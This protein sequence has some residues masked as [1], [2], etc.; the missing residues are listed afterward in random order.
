MAGLLRR[1][2][3]PLLGNYRKYLLVYGIAT[4]FVLF[5]GMAI[6]WMVDLP[7]AAPETY[8][9]EILLCVCIFGAS[10]LYRERQT[11]GK[12]YLKELLVL[13]MGIGVVSAVVYGLLILFYGSVIDFEFVE[14][15]VALRLE[16]MGSSS[17]P[18]ALEAI[19]Q[20]RH[21]SLG[22]WAFIGGFRS[23]VMSIII[24]FFSSIIFRTEQNIR[25]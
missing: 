22:D 5:F 21:Y 7:Y 6:S 25:R 17:E 11:G 2:K 18:A 13:G 20:V 4:G 10:Y 1:Y 9:T 14:R 12:I 24:M 3:S 19:E 8:V 16:Q 23:M 15:C